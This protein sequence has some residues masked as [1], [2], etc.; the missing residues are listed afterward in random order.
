MSIKVEVLKEA[1]GNVYEEHQ[2]YIQSFDPQWR[3]DE[4]IM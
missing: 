4:H 1:R 2:R 3:S